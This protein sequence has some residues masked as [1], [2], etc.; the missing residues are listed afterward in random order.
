M[1]KMVSMGIF[2]GCGVNTFNIALTNLSVASINKSQSQWKFQSSSI[3]N[4]MKLCPSEE[5]DQLK[6][7][8]SVIPTDV[9]FEL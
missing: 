5:Y 8:F 6:I 2:W 9:A 1:S 7:A 4:F 3:T